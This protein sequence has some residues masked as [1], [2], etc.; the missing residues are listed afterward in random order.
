M[1]LPPPPSPIAM[2]TENLGCHTKFVFV[3]EG[4]KSTEMSTFDTY[5]S[6]AKD[7]ILALEPFASNTTK[8]NFYK[9]QSVSTDS[10]ISTIT[11]P[12]NPTTPVTKNTAWG[13]FKNRMGSLYYLGMTSA[14]RDD[15][16]DEFGSMSGGNKVFIIIIANEGTYS[17]GAEFVNLTQ[18]DDTDYNTAVCIV[19]KGTNSSE[20]DFL[21]VHEFGHSF[22]DLDD[23]YEDSWFA[24]NAP[25]YESGTWNYPN[26]L[27]IKDTDPGNWVQGGRYVATGKW[28]SS[29]DCLMRSSNPSAFSTRNQGLLQDRIDAESSSCPGKSFTTSTNNTN[30]SNKICTLN[31]S[32]TRYHDGTFANPTTGDTIYTDAFKTTT[33][34]GLGQWWRVAVPMAND[35]I[36]IASNGE[37][38]DHVSSISCL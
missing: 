31:L 1:K 2:G 19:G 36:K 8:I 3:A 23:E 11:H 38:L 37:V 16:E 10:G 9:V 21:V 7:A 22:G 30:K 35:A 15:L 28:R 4:F 14:K 5:A 33:F 18:Y 20:F 26:R 12:V 24:T 32:A 34:N 25:T 6:D 13:V 17:G 29:T 27:N